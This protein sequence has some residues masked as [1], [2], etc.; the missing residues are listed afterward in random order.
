M[1]LMKDI[2]IDVSETISNYINMIKNN[3]ATRQELIIDI[4]TSYGILSISGCKDVNYIRVVAKLAF[5]EYKSLPSAG[6]EG[7]TP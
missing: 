6:V 1:S 4:I 5:R 3:P 2:K 7:F